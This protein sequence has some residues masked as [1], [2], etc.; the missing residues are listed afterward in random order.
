MKELPSHLN[1]RSLSVVP[2]FDAG[3]T[4]KCGRAGR[5]DRNAHDR[6]RKRVRA[7]HRAI[8]QA[9]IGPC[10]WHFW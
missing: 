8:L 4:R 1:E 2:D 3:A 6:L 10:G 9:C 5:A 7:A